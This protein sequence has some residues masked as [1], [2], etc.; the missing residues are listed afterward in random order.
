MSQ[1]IIGIDLGGTK[2][3]AAVATPEGEIIAR[4]KKRTLP[5]EQSDVGPEA[6]AR[7]IAETAEEAAQKA[8]LGMKKIAAVGVGAP[9]PTDI[10]TGH[11]FNAVNLPGW[12]QGFDLG[13][14]LIRLLGRPVFVD[15]AVNVGLLGEATYGAARGIDDVVG[16]FVGTGLG[17]ALVLDGKLRRGFRWGSGEVGHTY[18]HYPGHEPLDMEKVASR[19][20]ISRRL[21]EAVERGEAPV[22]ADLLAERSDGRITSGVIRKALAAGDPVTK[23][24]VADAQ[25][26]LGVLI[27]SITNLLDPQAFVLGGGLV[28]SLGEAFLEPIQQRARA[29]FFVRQRVEAVQIVAAGLGDDSGVLGAVALAVE[30]SGG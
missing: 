7:R 4:S 8:G 6:L 1:Y 16:L 10:H 15:N 30:Q 20:A 14:T 12:E 18:L 25:E 22:V 27:A 24:A 28:E 5:K 13:P 23:A 29:L 21:A 17:G 11:V 2:I 3:L 19:G 9:G 26:A